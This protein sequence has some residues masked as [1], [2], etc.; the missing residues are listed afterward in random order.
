MGTN[1]EFVAAAG[2]FFSIFKESN[3]DDYHKSVSKSYFFDAHYEIK[4]SFFGFF[5]FQKFKNRIHFYLLTRLKTLWWMIHISIV[6]SQV[7]HVSN[8]RISSKASL[9]LT[10]FDLYTTSSLDPNLW[11]Q[12]WG[13]L[14]VHH[15][16]HQKIP[17]HPVTLNTRRNGI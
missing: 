13:S 6:G 5:R 17:L 2:R 8:F 1:I 9:C 10:E 11:L 4:G 7:A 12:W 3:F 15:H 14:G 16:H